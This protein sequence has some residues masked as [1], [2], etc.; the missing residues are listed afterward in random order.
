MI[1]IIIMKIYIFIY[2]INF[3]ILIILNIYKII[4]GKKKKYK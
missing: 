1:Y 2:D 4:N 3:N